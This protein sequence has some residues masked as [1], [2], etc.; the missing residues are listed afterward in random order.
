MRALD[1]ALASVSVDELSPAEPLPA[2]SPVVVEPE[3]DAP[4]AFGAEFALRPGPDRPG[5]SS[6][7]RADL[8]ALLFRGRV[9]AEIRGRSVD[10]GDGHPFLAAERLLS[11]ARQSLETW[12]RGQQLHVRGEAGGIVFGIR[13][14]ADGQLAFSLG[15]RH[16]PDALG[17]ARS[18]HTFPAL[19]VVDVVE[20]SLAFG[21]ALVRSILRRD[22]S[23]SSNLRL[24]AFRRSL[25]ETGDALREV[26]RKD[27]KVN[28]TP[29]PYRAFAIARAASRAT[30][31]PMP[32]GTKLRYSPRWRA[33]VPGIDLRATFLCGERLIVGAAAE[34]FCL[35]RATGEIFWRVETERA[36][37]VVTPGGLARIHA[38]GLLTMH[39]FGTGEIALRTWLAPRT[40]GPASGAVVH[41]QGLPRLLI[42]TEGERHLV[43]ID[44]TSGEPRWRHAWG[45]A[46][47]RKAGSRAPLGVPRMKRAGKLLYF[48][49]GDSALTAL[50]VLTGAA[51]WRIR[52]RLRFRTA[53][54]LDHDALFA[55]AGG[56]SSAA[57]LHS[58]DPFS[59][60][61]RW[62]RTVRPLPSGGGGPCTVEGPVLS[63]AGVV[64]L[65]V[66]DREG[67]KLVAYDRESG[68]RRWESPAR[69]APSGTSWIAVDDLFI[70][71]TPT[72]EVVAIEA[73]T[74]ALRYRHL[75]GRAL[76]HDVPRRLEPVLRSGA[77]FVPHTDVRVLRPS[78]GALVGSI[79]PCDAIPDL[80]R[81][82]ERCDVYVAEESGHLVAFGAGPRLALVKG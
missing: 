63:A 39:D 33:L 49:S 44:L 27:S 22:R 20:A 15:A 53:P 57:Q 76:E 45:G 8:H 82:D 51:V 52:D 35:N 31:A 61:V 2:L 79:S 80:L 21:R 55:L 73:S 54:T 38:D 14:A 43:A 56:S 74:G 23:Q 69:V 41:V 25:R 3:A 66:R 16:A 37:S 6:V 72:G 59:G 12:E 70:G 30:E 24:S 67:L 78:D 65:P 4:V 71:N 19:S 60:R 5:E 46:A 28:P 40:S 32:A 9:R 10:L 50:D 36:T 64:A 62:S 26:C 77:L 13:L 47:A 75:L 17:Q 48:V 34:T 81:V 7:E 18:L 29:E 11:L 68:A 42:V 1:D 58:I